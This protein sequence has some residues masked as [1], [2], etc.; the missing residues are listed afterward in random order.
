MFT[1]IIERVT[2]KAD[3]IKAAEAA[4]EKASADYHA[5]KKLFEFIDN[6]DDAAVAHVLE[7][8]GTAM[9][10]YWEAADQYAALTKKDKITSNYFRAKFAM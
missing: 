2:R 4:C 7:M 3:K 5:A 9:N 1:K 8:C 10:R 6:G